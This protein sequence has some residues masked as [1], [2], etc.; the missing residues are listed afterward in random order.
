MSGPP[1]LE[2]SRWARLARQIFSTLPSSRVLHV[3][4]DD[5]ALV[6][7]LVRLGIDACAHR[8]GAE[9]A[10][11][12]LTE[13]RIDTDPQGLD[14]HP[15]RAFSTVI[16]SLVAGDDGT[17]DVETGLPAIT[18]LC[19]RHLVIV[20]VGSDDTRV[21]HAR[22][23]QLEAT[24]IAAGFR[25]HP[26]HLLFASYVEPVAASLPLVLA[27][28]RAPALP[29]A[30]PDDLLRETTA[31]AE[32]RASSY[33]LAAQIVRRLDVVV[34]VGGGDGAGPAI[35]HDGSACAK[36]IAIDDRAPLL[37]YGRAAYGADRRRLA[38]IEGDTT[39][40]D[41]VADHSADVVVAL[42]PQTYVTGGDR[43]LENVVRVLLPGGRA[44]IAAPGL[45]HAGGSSCATF[46][47]RLGTAVRIERFFGR[48]VYAVDPVEM[49]DWA[50][51]PLVSA[52]AG[53]AFEADGWV[54]IGV[55]DCVTHQTPRPEQIAHPRTSNPSLDARAAADG[56]QNP[57]LPFGMVMTGT[58]TIARDLLV[59]LARRTLQRTPKSPGDRGAALC[60][61]A[62]RML[63]GDP[64]LF[65]ERTVIE[66]LLEAYV[67][68]T[69]RAPIEHRWRIS[70]AYV[71]GQIYLRSGRLDK[72]ER[73]FAFCAGQDAMAYRPLIA[74]KT[75]DAAFHAGWLA[76]RR[77]DADTAR[78]H[79][80]QGLESARRAVGE[81]WDAC[82]GPRD[83]AFPY[84]LREATQIV[85]AADRCY[86]ALEWASLDDDRI[87]ELSL[88]AFPGLFVEDE[89][90]ALTAPIT[91]DAFVL[92]AR[93]L[94]AGQRHELDRL[95]QWLG[96]PVY[97]WGAG[98]LG[99]WFA[100]ELGERFATVVTGFIDSDATKV[101]TS[102][103]GKP[104][105]PPAVALD[106]PAAARPFV[107]VASRFADEIAARLESR[108][109]VAHDD[110]DVVVYAPDSP[111]P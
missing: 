82:L 78:R 33:A 84:G 93:P 71:L 35:L 48:F 101:G 58:R 100:G 69:P 30:S 22:R 103:E 11:T 5:L 19:E 73:A 98:A 28:E 47:G 17:L 66:A 111:T 23:R 83:E 68:A 96:R 25:K 4:A 18:R 32:Q 107:L 108:G 27:F 20:L 85:A 80:Q 86:Q 99:R 89:P 13:A 91:A 24:V 87:R 42:D 43:F 94:S 8:A 34:D 53:D 63:E 39:T 38:L 109:Y 81:G 36:V 70:N 97:V 54:A 56:Y 57:W 41:G 72:A 64:S 26:A 14:R 51:A 3:G 37:E 106:A 67:A 1:R 61:L 90:P 76:H 104:I 31:P 75:V 55:K 15:D 88:L 2:R 65:V 102:F 52:A 7:E 50:L 74:T 6:E 10:R 77:G 29:A 95:L 110:Y 105:H 16:H 59:E 45:A 62:Y 44:V 9:S 40:L 49:P 46:L 60:V 12:L 79:W 21:A 92:P